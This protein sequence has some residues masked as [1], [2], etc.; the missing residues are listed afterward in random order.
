MFF[1]TLTRL[2]RLL[3]DAGLPQLQELVLERALETRELLLRLLGERLDRLDVLV[4]LAVEGLDEE[5]HLADAP[6]LRGIGELLDLRLRGACG[7]S[8]RSFTASRRESASKRARSVVE[9]R[10]SYSRRIASWLSGGSLPRSMLA[11]VEPMVSWM[12]TLCPVESV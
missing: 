4:D 10:V 12:L 6:V 8:R 3:E 9:N 1:L 7:R 2:K 11:T 5:V